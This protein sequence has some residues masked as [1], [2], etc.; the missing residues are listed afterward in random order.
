MRVVVAQ[1]T[2]HMKIALCPHLSL[3]HYRGGEKWTATLANRLAAD[4][5]EVAVRA[6]PYT[7]RDERRVA[8]DDVL[9]EG[10]SYR[11]RWHHDLSA[12]DSAYLF[13]HPFAR[14]FFTGETQAIAGIHSWIYLTTRLYEPHYGVVP[15]AAKLLYRAL[16][17]HAF[18]RFD[19]VHT[20][21][22]SYTSPHPNTHYIPNFVDTSLFEPVDGGREEPFTVL[23]T[24]AQLRSKGWDRTQA[25]AA[26][27]SD[28]LRV[29][30]TGDSDHPAIEGLGFLDEEELADAYANAH[31]VLHPTRIDADSLVLKEALAAGTPVVTTP[32]RTHPPD[33]DAVLHGSTVGDLVARLRTL[34]WE[35]AHDG[36]YNRRCRRAREVGERSS[37]DMVYPQLKALLTTPERIDG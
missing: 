2:A 27:L 15:T 7:P 31:A 13:Y 25:V 32:L 8:A 17:E 35:W 29:V 5:F 11:E 18:D 28:E 26:T 1:T 21:T 3:E 33:G 16:G 34:Q 22:D 24:A 20:V 4:G 12:F 19:A 10:V 30:T 9:D 6:L 37:V 23:V 36:G 14:S